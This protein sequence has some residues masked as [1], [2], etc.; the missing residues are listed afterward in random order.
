[1]HDRDTATWD[2]IFDCGLVIFKEYQPG[3]PRPREHFTLPHGFPHRTKQLT[4]VSGAAKT[5]PDLVSWI[6][7]LPSATAYA[8][9]LETV[10]GCR[11][12]LW[13]HAHDQVCALPP[14]LHLKP[15]KYRLGD[16][17]PHPSSRAPNA[18]IRRW[19]Y[20]PL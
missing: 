2:F 19:D 4:G 20:G 10:V 9:Y 7:T 8:G 5:P 15:P 12:R 6:L 11:K 1:M 3:L 14:G 17:P 18:L 13:Q 16:R